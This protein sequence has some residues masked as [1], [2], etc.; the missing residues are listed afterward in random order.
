MI[1]P[2]EGLFKLTPMGKWCYDVHAPALEEATKLAKHQTAFQVLCFFCHLNT[3]FLHNAAAILALHPE[4]SCHPI[5][6]LPVFAK[7]KFK[8]HI[9]AMGVAL[10]HKSNPMDTDLEKVLPGVHRWH[11]A[12]QASIDG[13][14]T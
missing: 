3:V 7:V 8:E 2:P 4:R 10:I 9:K 12:N 14:A 1:Q 13:V 5:F 6:D 11:Q